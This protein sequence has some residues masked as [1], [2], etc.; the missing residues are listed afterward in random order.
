MNH[1]NMVAAA[2]QARCQW[3]QHPKE[4]R[5][6]E[7]ERDIN[8][9]TMAEHNSEE[10]IKYIRPLRGTRMV[11]FWIFTTKVD[12]KLPYVYNA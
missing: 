1:P 12:N 8:I 9:Q 7:K 11:F 5:A 6:A 2:L 4:P 3:D 10:F